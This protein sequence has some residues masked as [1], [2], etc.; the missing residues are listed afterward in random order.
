DPADRFPSYRPLIEA[1]QPF[2]S[3]SPTPAGLGERFLAALID[4]AVLAAL[5]IP[6][7]FF[8]PGLQA[9][10]QPNFAVPFRAFVPAY[11]L[12]L[13]YYPALGG[14]WGAWIGKALCGLRVVTR[15]G[16]K[17]GFARAL[18]RAFVFTTLGSAPGMLAIGLGLP[19]SKLPAWLAGWADP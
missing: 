8:I 10:F 6:L 18:L 9:A 17:P 7:F 2:D 5:T 16:E 12:Q 11:V 1:L 14:R 3:T 4:R 19:L 15:A 13:C